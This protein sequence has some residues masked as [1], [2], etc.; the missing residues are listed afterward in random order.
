MLC[1]EGCLKITETAGAVGDKDVIGSEALVQMH[2]SCLAALCVVCFGNEPSAKT[3]MGN[4]I[5][6]APVGSFTA[7]RAS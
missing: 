7:H 5:D 3:T 4:R 6:D 2:N 1:A